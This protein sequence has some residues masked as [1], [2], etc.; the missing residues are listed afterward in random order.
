L[1]HEIT[2]SKNNGNEV[3]V[4]NLSELNNVMEKKLAILEALILG[5]VSLKR[6]E[7]TPI[8]RTPGDTTIVGHN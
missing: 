3:I 2:G 5:D 4:I 8:K 1:R 6:I 7:K